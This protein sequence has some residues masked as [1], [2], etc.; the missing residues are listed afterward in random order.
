MNHFNNLTPAELERLA[1]LSEELGETQQAIGK[2]LR[3]GFDNYDPEKPDT[4]NRMDLHK[5][6]ADVQVA[7]DI[8]LNNG[9]LKN[10][11]LSLFRRVKRD[12]VF[13]FMHH[14]KEPDYIK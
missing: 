7:V 4:N 3:H 12:K 2:I 13:K 14:N 9:D 1:L 8:M 11:Q 10:S 6:I 5:E